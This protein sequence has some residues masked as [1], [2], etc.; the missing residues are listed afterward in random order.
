MRKTGPT[1]GGRIRQRERPAKHLAEH[2]LPF[3]ES[4]A[5]ALEVSELTE[6]IDSESM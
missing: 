4:R 1:L 6:R 5:Y 2:L 3:F